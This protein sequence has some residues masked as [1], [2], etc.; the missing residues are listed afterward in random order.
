MVQP[1]SARC[2]R[3]LRGRWPR[4]RLCPWPRALQPSSARRRSGVRT[5]CRDLEAVDLLDGL[6]EVTS[7]WPMCRN[8]KSMTFWAIEEA[9]Q[10]PPDREAAFSGARN[11]ARCHSESSRSQRSPISRKPPETDLYIPQPSPVRGLRNRRSLVRIQSGACV[12]GDPGSPAPCGLRGVRN[13]CR[14]TMCSNTAGNAATETRSGS[15]L[16]RTSH[17]GV[18]RRGR[19]YVAVYL[20][21]GRQ[22]KETVSSF[23]E[24]RAVKV[25]RQAESRAERLGPKA[26]GATR[27]EFSAPRPRPSSG[28]SA[29]RSVIPSAGAGGRPPRCPPRPEDGGRA[30]AS[31]LP[32]SSASW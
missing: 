13:V 16:I 28:F 4:R 17:P 6:Q 10:R 29:I 2:P 3:P 8:V 15:A 26:E 27:L 9:R 22:R 31:R 5:I 32:G 14:S 20:R 18:Y 24:A 1:T 11:G 12:P 19:R 25:A 7:K 30:H 23:A 21:D